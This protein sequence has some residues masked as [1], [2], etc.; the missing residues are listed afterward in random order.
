MAA[1]L[2]GLELLLHRD[3]RGGSTSSL[4]AAASTR[5]CG[6]GRL[7]PKAG[8]EPA[9]ISP[10]APQTCA[11]TNSATWAGFERTI[12]TSWQARWASP[13]YRSGPIREGGLAGSRAPSTW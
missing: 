3:D 11:S 6:D 7:V 13:W 2:R 1:R 10:H 5:A 8:L 9:R 4:T 12:V